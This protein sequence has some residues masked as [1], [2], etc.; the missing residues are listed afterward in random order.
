MP[1]AALGAPLAALLLL[2]AAL[3]GCA[4][5]PATPPAEP[6]PEQ[7]E[8]ARLVSSA[9]AAEASANQTDDQSEFAKSLDDKFHTHNYWGGSMEKMLMDADV[10]SGDML[11]VASDPLGFFTS[12][13]FLVNNGFT[14]FDLPD[15]S[16]VPPEAE[17][18]EVQVAWAPSPTITGLQLG[19]RNASTEDF[20]NEGDPFPDGGGTVVIPTTVEANDQPHTTVSKWR[21]YL[22]PVNS[23]TPFGGFGGLF[24]GSV[25]VTIKAFRND[26][27]F[28]APPHPDFWHDN[29]TLLLANYTGHLKGQRAEFPIF[30]GFATDEDDG[31]FVFL[32]LPNGTIVPP[33]TGLLTLTINYH[34]SASLPNAFQ[35]KPEVVYS[36]ANTRRVLA[37]DGEQPGQDQIVYTIA[38]DNKMV[39]S[40]YANES[41]WFFIVAIDSDAPTDTGPFFGDVGFFDG[42]WSMTVVAERE[43]V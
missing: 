3:A 9:E 8:E 25:H 20:D 39:D 13:R 11:P 15:G 40:P 17:R 42:D 27:L 6:S 28:I 2:V 16:I 31:G 32:E 12:F 38:V 4:S 24:N 19:W 33:H 7:P 10:Q 35:V 1:R 21:F 43:Q 5:P 36:P 14:A 26:T 29:T 22:A 41:T 23:A 30:V 37:P 18:V 34:N